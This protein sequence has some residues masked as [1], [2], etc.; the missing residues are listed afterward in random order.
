MFRIT[1]PVSEWPRGKETS[2][3]TERLK[4]MESDSMD[5]GCHCD[6]LT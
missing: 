4:K 5:S 1:S 2:F 6:A 3:Q